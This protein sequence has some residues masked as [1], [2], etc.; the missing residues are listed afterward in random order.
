DTTPSPF[1]QQLNDAAQASVSSAPGA[2]GGPP[3]SIPCVQFD[4][5][6]FSL[7]AAA[8]VQ[9]PIGPRVSITT[10]EAPVHAGVEVRADSP[11]VGGAMGT[12]SVAN[13]IPLGAATEAVAPSTVVQR[14]AGEEELEA[15][16]STTS[17][18]RAAATPGTRATST[19]DI[20]APDTIALE[21]QPTPTV[22]TTR[23]Q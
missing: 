7:E 11:E 2:G 15:Q 6:Q 9:A 19:P 16:A 21:T 8:A 17:E 10:D 1:A 5:A 23:I 22:T 3:S 4:P 12:L 13:A 14:T 20:N 18:T